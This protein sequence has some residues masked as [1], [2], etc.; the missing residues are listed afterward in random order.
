MRLKQDMLSLSTTS[1]RV[2]CI[3]SNRSSYLILGF[4][5]LS[6]SCVSLR[7]VIRLTNL[8]LSVA[9]QYCHLASRWE[10][11]NVGSV[12]DVLACVMFTDILFYCIQSVRVRWRQIHPCS[13]SSIKESKNVFIKLVCINTFT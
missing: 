11:S 10:R 8:L 13:D 2:S 7:K 6:L 3:Y 4:F 9:R 1:Y 5:S 12:I